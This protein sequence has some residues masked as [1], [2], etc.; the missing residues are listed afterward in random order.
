M[1]LPPYWRRKA[2]TAWG[3][4]VPLSSGLIPRF[5]ALL[6]HVL[7]EAS[8]PGPHL[9]VSFI[10]FLPTTFLWPQLGDREDIGHIIILPLVAPN[11]FHLKLIVLSPYFLY[12]GGFKLSLLKALGVH[13]I[14]PSLPYRFL[15]CSRRFRLRACAR[16]V[17]CSPTVV[18]F[19]VEVLIGS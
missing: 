18:T 11:L 9:A 14:C 6:P 17:P 10:K 12:L 5:I 19:S 7:G 16:Q 3:L 2:S 13:Y 8:Q 15:S 4:R 1:G